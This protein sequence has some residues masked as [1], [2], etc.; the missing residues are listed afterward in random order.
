MTI[1]IARKD[2]CMCVIAITYNLGVMLGSH[3]SSKWG[4]TSKQVLGSN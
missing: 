4:L 1:T 2:N 3:D